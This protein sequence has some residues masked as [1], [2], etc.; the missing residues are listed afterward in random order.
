MNIFKRRDEDRAIVKDNVFDC[1]MVSMMK[2]L[3][4]VKFK[5]I[6]R[7]NIDNDSRCSPTTKQPRWGKISFGRELKQRKRE[8]IELQF[9]IDMRL[10]F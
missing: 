1:R 3:F 2:T 5:F 4:E 7:L 10:P 8:R 6:F 9:L